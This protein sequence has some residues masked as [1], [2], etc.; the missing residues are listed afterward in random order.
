MIRIAPTPSGFLHE[1]NAFSFLITEKIAKKNDLKIF[2]RIDDLDADRKRSEYVKDIFESLHW[3]EIKW[4]E[5]PRNEDDFE[6]NWTQNNRISLYDAA[7]KKL[8]K[9]KHV[10]ACTCTRKDLG[11]YDGRYPGTCTHKNIPLNENETALRLIVPEGTLVE[12]KDE[13]LGEQKI[14]LDHEMG[15]FVIRRHDGIPAYH[16]ASVVDDIHFGITWIVRGN[17]LLYST[18]GQ[19]FLAEK[20]G[21]NNFWKTKFLHHILIPDQHGEK[22]SK[23]EGALSMKRMREDGMKG[24]DL[25]EKFGH[26]LKMY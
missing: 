4:N 11:M 24:K 14:E 8:S 18:A 15:S 26:L 19:I 10:F 20:L 23:S 13:H 7:L 21:K 2:L 16:L 6:R 25:R 12:F 5:G 17:D 9:N 3:L 1:G 22:L